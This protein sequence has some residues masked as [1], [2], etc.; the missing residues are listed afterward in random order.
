LWRRAARTPAS[1]R[2]DSRR[3]RPACVADG[4]RRLGTRTPTPPAFCVPEVV[5]PCLGGSAPLSRATDGGPGVG[6]GGRPVRR[7]PLRD[8]FAPRCRCFC[9]A[10]ARGNDWGE[11]AELYERLSHMLPTPVVTL[12][13]AVTVAMAD[14]PA[15]GLELVE[16]LESSGA[17]AGYHLLPATRADL[18]RRLGR[19][20]EAAGAYPAGHLVGWHRRRTL[21]GPPARRDHA[22]RRVAGAGRRPDSRRASIAAIPVRRQGDNATPLLEEE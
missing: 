5:R 4:S 1:S 20:A 18:L 8:R 13:R 19:C 6:S 9:A 22:S 15:A 14:R 3:S 7:V 17:L 2:C 10:I 11:T 16:E 21:P 12:N